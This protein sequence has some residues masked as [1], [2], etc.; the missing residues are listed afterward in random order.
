MSSVLTLITAY[1][2]ILRDFQEELI[3]LLATEQSIKDFSSWQ[4][5]YQQER[6]WKTPPGPW[7]DARLPYEWRYGE[8]AWRA[9]ELYDRWLR[10]EVLRAG[11]EGE[12]E[13]AIECGEVEVKGLLEAE[14]VNHILAAALR[15]DLCLG[16]DGL[17]GEVEQL[18]DPKFL[19]KAPAVD[20]RHPV[21]SLNN[22]LALAMHHILHPYSNLCY[23]Y[24]NSDPCW[25]VKGVASQPPPSPAELM[26]EMVEAAK[27]GLRKQ[28]LLD[29]Q[30][31]RG[32]VQYPMRVGE[33]ERSGWRDYDDGSAGNAA[34][35]D[36]ARD[37]DDNLGG[38]DN[39]DDCLS[40]FS[41]D[42][43]DGQ[44]GA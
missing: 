25:V 11:E 1:D 36:D 41:D 23:W 14:L 15:Y 12:Y 32:F 30:T 19:G 29:K 39:D 7:P 13:E 2:R 10:G 40:D 26:R 18:E 20:A 9:V 44:C 24:C 6:Q 33:P 17:E 31:G 27:A 37:D 43:S 8:R 42:N 34:K 21:S 5:G 3:A 28:H 35:Y 38:N 22:R 16:D 4:M